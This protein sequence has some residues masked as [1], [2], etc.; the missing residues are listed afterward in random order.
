[1]NA[2]ATRK[3]SSASVQ[4]PGTEASVDLS[5][6]NAHLATELATGLSNAAAVRERYGITDAQWETLKKNELF[7]AMLADAI[8]KWRGDHNANARIQLKADIVL[9]DAIPAYDTMIH[10]DKIPASERINAG[11]LLAQLAG[12]T[13]KE[14]AAAG[15]AHGGF[16]L[17]INLAN[18]GEKLVIDGKAIPVV[19]EPT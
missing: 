1:M 11:K 7:R 16:T 3:T 9:E 13:S 5:H 8:Q 15:P 4:V 12:R 10:S 14:G 19:D 18:G 6:L 17:N 2:P